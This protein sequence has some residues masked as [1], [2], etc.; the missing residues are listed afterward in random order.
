MREYV[1]NVSLFVWKEV[2]LM[3]EH[4]PKVGEVVVYTDEVGVEHDALV[5]A[6][7]AGDRPDGALNLL[8]VTKDNSKT[9][10]YGNQIERASS[11]SRE[12]PNTT[13]HGRFWNPKS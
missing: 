11:V 9:D 5:T 6:Y 7:W 13:A 8:Y 1:F 12:N 2:K 4:T 3:S 10:S